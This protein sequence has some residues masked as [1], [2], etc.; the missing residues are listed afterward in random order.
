MS[1]SAMEHASL[2]LAYKIF[3]LSGETDAVWGLLGSELS[4]EFLVC[5]LIWLEG[6]CLPPIRYIM[7]C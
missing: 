3:P 6:V 4:E 7:L 5:E 2:K 1:V